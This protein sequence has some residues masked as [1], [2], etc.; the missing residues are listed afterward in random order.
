VPSFCFV[1]YSISHFMSLTFSFILYIAWN[2]SYR[3]IAIFSVADRRGGWRF[4]PLRDHEGVN[5][6]ALFESVRFPWCRWALKLMWRSEYWPVYLL[7]FNASTSECHFCNHELGS[8][9]SW[10]FPLKWIIC[11]SV[12]GGTV[13]TNS[14]VWNSVSLSLRHWC[15]C[16]IGLLYSLKFKSLLVKNDRDYKISF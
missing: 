3:A 12:R 4:F 9:L 7:P 10:I 2:P 11:F 6:L 16:E 13:N 15:F 1:K 5:I 14:H 8:F